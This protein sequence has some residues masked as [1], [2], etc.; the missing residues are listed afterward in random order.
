[1]RVL[2]LFNK[3]KKI[4]KDEYIPADFVLLQSSDKKGIVFQLS[5][6]DQ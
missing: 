4:H 6:S 2:M 3:R 5:M 1:M